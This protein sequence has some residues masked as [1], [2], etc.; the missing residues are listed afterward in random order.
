MECA[1]TGSPNDRRPSA[2]SRATTVATIDFVSEPTPKQLA[3]ETGTAVLVSATPYHVN[4]TTPSR[5]MP[6]AAP[7]TRCAPACS[8]TRSLR[9]CSVDRRASCTPLV[10]AS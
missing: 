3:A 5:R 1:A 7:G 8:R 2:A 6:R 10:C 9:S 4:V